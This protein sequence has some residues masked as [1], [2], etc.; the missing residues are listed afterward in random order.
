[1]RPLNFLSAAEVNPKWPDTSLFKTEVGVDCLTVFKENIVRS[2]NLCAL[3]G[4][5]FW[6]GVEWAAAG[7][8]ASRELIGEV[9]PTLNLLRPV[10]QE[11]LL[12]AHK[13]MAE[14][15]NIPAEEQ[16]LRLRMGTVKCETHMS[17]SGDAVMAMLERQLQSVIIQSWTAFEVLCSD[18]LRR[19][20]FG[21]P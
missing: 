4:F 16:R 13:Y 11:L 10:Q 15:M 8:R 12:L 3:P 6:I 9:N 19:S 5:A 21:T 7:T 18:L 1:M 17:F 20:G 2:L 14:S